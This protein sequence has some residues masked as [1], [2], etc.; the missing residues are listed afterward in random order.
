MTRR[1]QMGSRCNYKAPVA[2]KCPVNSSREYKRTDALCIVCVSRV[3]S[4]KVGKGVWRSWERSIKTISSRTGKMRRTR[5][6]SSNSCPPIIQRLGSLPLTLSDTSSVMQISRTHARWHSSAIL[7]PVLTS[8][9]FP[10]R[11]L[12]GEKRVP[13]LGPFK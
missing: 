5:S 7:T 11:L 1:Q 3:L 13:E 2:P 12:K 9:Y 6:A 8:F 10:F 4:Q